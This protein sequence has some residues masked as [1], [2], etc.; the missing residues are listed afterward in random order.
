MNSSNSNTK[1]Q[2]K[3]WEYFSQKEVSDYL[4]SKFNTITPR[5]TIL[6]KSVF[7]DSVM[8]C[9]FDD[10]SF[11]LKVANN[12]CSDT[13]IEFS[14]SAA[15]NDKMQPIFDEIFKWDKVLKCSNPFYVRLDKDSYRSILIES[16]HQGPKSFERYFSPYDFF[17]E[18][19]KKEEN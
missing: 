14:F 12:H 16:G 2:T 17:Y 5:F 1:N 8:L 19:I 15:D 18:K 11:I 6:S 9:K 7:N 13:Y 3:H 4:A 10:V